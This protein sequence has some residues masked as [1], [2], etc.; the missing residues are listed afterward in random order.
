MKIFTSPHLFR[1]LFLF[2]MVFCLSFQL[3]AGEIILNHEKAGITFSGS[4]YQKLDFTIQLSSIQFRDIQTPKGSFTE[5]FVE[6]Y[7]SRNVVGDPKLPV[8]HKLIEAP[9]NSTFNVT[10]E[11]IEYIEYDLASSGISSKLIPAQAPL[12]KNITDPDEIPFVFNSGTYQKNEFTGDELVTVTPV[13]IMRSVNLANLAIAPFLYNP[14]TNKIR[15]FTKLEVTVTFENADVP[16]T[17]LL[18]KRTSSPFF[19]KLYSQLPNYQSNTDELITSGPVTYVIVSDPNFQDALQPFIQWKTQKGFKVIQAYTNNPEVGTTK[20]SIRNYLMGLYNTPPAGYDPPSFILFA[21]D[22]GQIPAFSVNSHPTDLNYCEYTNDHIPEVYYGRFAAQNLTQLQSYIDKSLEYEQYTM[23]V[24][25]F[26]NEVVMVAGADPNYGQLYGNGQINYGTNNYFNAAHNLISHT[27]LQPEPGGGNYSQKIRNNVSNGVAFANYTAHGSEAGW[28]DPQF[29]TSQIAALQNI[30]KYPL[31]VGNCCKTSNFA[32]TCFAKEITRVANKGALGYIGCSDY[33]YW[34]E[35][36]W[37]GCGFKT[38]SVN[39]LYKAL[40][41]G[42]YDVTFHD[43]GETIDKW[44][45]TMGQMV[46]GGNL[47]VEESS[48]SMKDYYWETYCLMGDPSLSIYFSV[49]QLITASYPDNLPVGTSSM[50]VNTEPFAYVSLSVHDS[51]LLDAKCADSLGVADL[52]F[53]PVTEVCN[54]NIVISKQNR[55][56]LIDSIPLLPFILTIEASADTL[57]K[58]GSSNLSVIVNGGSGTF[59]YLWSPGTFLDNPAIATPVSTPDTNIAYAVT[60]D[61]G[62]YSVTSPPFYLAVNPVPSTPVITL[63]QDTLISSAQS[64]NQWY[65]YQE[66]IAGATEPKYVPVISGDYYVIVSDPVTRCSS[67]PSNIIAYYFTG[68]S[69]VKNNQ[70]VLI[71]PNPFKDFVTI[72]YDLPEPGSVLISLF[73]AVG[74]EIML[75]ENNSQQDAGL[76]SIVMKG[77]FL[78]KGLYYIKVQTKNYSVSKKLILTR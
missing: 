24:D 7:G 31:M 9:L 37:W 2:L 19:G 50:T 55:K 23:P 62:T 36:F 66:M 17:I 3:F 67:Q 27:Y 43:H 8:F 76:H 57:C 47:A 49:P 56:P 21:G 46:V 53:T 20:T 54:L 30:H 42:A 74:K 28:A 10:F 52:V 1:K 16:G 77:Q 18:K 63:G 34:D 60:V 40:H 33:S 41:L 48:S 4:T 69:S 59:T 11:K 45:V 39:P 78:D 25:T 64:G 12:S 68:V 26:L 22:V 71:Y 61:D 38:V 70:G 13:G 75:L 29:S 14:V 73:D 58:G 51:T 72:S 65:R 15:V 35:D 5:L 6:G 32:V 44:Y